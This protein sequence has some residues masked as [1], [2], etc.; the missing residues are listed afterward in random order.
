MKVHILMFLDGKSGELVAPVEIY[1]E[2]EEGL[3][4]L[5]A[6]AK[7]L[8]APGEYAGVCTVDL[9]EFVTDLKGQLSAIKK[10]RPPK[11]KHETVGRGHYSTCLACGETKE[12]AAFAASRLPQCCDACYLEGVAE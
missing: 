11:V 10:V 4:D 5:L 6:D 2:A 3:A 8:R 12:P 9:T 1:H 7:R